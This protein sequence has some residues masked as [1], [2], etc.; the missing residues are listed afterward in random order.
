MS[1]DANFVEALFYLSL[2]IMAPALYK[3]SRVIVRQ[4]WNR[5]VSDAEIII[6]RKRNGA[7]VSVQ[8][9]K[10][11]GYVVDQLKAARSNA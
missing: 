10:T 2:M 6:T 9:I 8:R 11:T 4:L 1:V 3:I 5:Y 7:V